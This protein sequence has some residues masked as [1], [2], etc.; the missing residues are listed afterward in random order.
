[1][2]K[3]TLMLAGLFL[4]GATYAHEGKACCKKDEK[5][6]KEATCKRSESKDGKACCK[7][8]ASDKKDKAKK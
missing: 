4:V 1:M 3:L 8:D 6:S 7:K 5:C 2:K